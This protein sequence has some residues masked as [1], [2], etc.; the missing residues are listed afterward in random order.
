MRR[1][2]APK[3]PSFAALVQQFFTEYLVAQRAVSP[4]TV[5]CYRD[6]L[7]LFLDFASGKLGKAPTA[8]RLA[9]I[10]P[11]L[12]LAF[13]D[14]LE[15]G[16]KNSVRSR[17]LR[18]T[19]LRAFLKFAGRRDVTSLHDVERALAVPMKR[20]ERP[21]LGFLSRTE[22]VAVLGQ[23]GPSWSSQ[24]DHLLLAM[25]YNTGA[26]VSEIIGVRVVDVV[27]DGGACVHLHGKG[28][29]LRS[30][31][32]WAATVVEIR[33]WMRLNP[34]L[35]GE[36]ALLPN[37]D[38]QAMS[39]SNVAQRLDIAVKRASA[40]QPNL[41]K[42]RVSPHTLRH[43]SAMHLLQSGVPFNVIAL[44]LGHESTT[45]T[46]RYVEAD[47]AMKEKALGRLEAPDAKLRRYQAPD[48]LMRFLQT[49]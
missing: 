20:F 28:P 43:T 16:R 40:E 32:L 15:H 36:A 31:P 5:A 10:Q 41:L 18:L 12:I 19:A 11:D 1:A 38:G 30:I 34:T 25:L 47:L 4:R 9:D 13:L 6:A 42:K 35:R 44:W 14:H 48:S 37:R 3:P 49:L 24:R 45:T 2:T 17:N 7:M 46:H 21:M 22:M 33:A 29:K 27:L 8:M 39:R 26:R 23:P